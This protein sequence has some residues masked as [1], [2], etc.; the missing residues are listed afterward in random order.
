[1]EIV[2]VEDGVWSGN[3]VKAM[4]RLVNGD[5][6]VTAARED[7]VVG[8]WGRVATREVSNMQYRCCHQGSPPG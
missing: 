1:M 6:D 2:N 4:S 3:A 7:M 8:T 5:E